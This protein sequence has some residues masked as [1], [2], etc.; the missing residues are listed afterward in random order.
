MQ[1][2]VFPNA[3]RAT[4]YK[5]RPLLCLWLRVISRTGSHRSRRVTRSQS[6]ASS[7]IGSGLRTT[8]LVSQLEIQNGTSNRSTALVRRGR[9]CA[10]ISSKTLAM[11]V[12]CPSDHSRPGPA[13]ITC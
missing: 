6:P 1:T 4:Q 13:A 8:L 12:A 2:T 10:S 11:T 5:H 9:L 7:P 3:D